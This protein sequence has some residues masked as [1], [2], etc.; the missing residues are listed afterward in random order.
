MSEIFFN[1]KNTFVQ[2]IEGP[3]AF[4]HRRSFSDSKIIMDDDE[5]TP[6]YSIKE[7]ERSSKVFQY[8]YWDDQAVSTDG[9]S[10]E[11][12]RMLSSSSTE[13]T[14]ENRITGNRM[15]VLSMNQ[16]QNP[17]KLAR[18][19][20]MSLESEGDKDLELILKNRRVDLSFLESPSSDVTGSVNIYS[21]RSFSQQVKSPAI[22]PEQEPVEEKIRPLDKAM[23]MYPAT[24][25]DGKTTVMLRNIPCRYTQM[26]LLDEVQ[27]FGYEID[28][29]YLPPARH[30]NRNLGYG[31]LNF[32]R[33]D[34]CKAFME[35]WKGHDWKIWKHSPKVAEVTYASLQGF[36][37]N[38]NYFKDMKISKAKYRPY[39]GASSDEE[40]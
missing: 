30:N 1:A 3:P 19:S 16:G 37:A 21:P 38:I 22:L 28:F 11:S 27:E 4:L 24:T 13:L 25:D 20:T 2:C 5:M 35:K 29:L 15:S 18:L 31:F 32:R 8:D 9:P 10:A 34:D 17:V 40:K 12:L 6:I 26:Q 14:I 36:E 39:T 23:Q 33:P 7:E